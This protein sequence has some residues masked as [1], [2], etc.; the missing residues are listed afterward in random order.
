MCANEMDCNTR[1][2]EMGGVEGRVRIKR[3]ALGGFPYPGIYLK[4]NLHVQA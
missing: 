4:N 3:G 2:C 1:D